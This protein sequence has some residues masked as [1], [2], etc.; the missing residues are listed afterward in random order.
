[1]NQIDTYWKVVNIVFLKNHSHVIIE[2][3]V[4]KL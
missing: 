4:L 1:M 3:P 2:K